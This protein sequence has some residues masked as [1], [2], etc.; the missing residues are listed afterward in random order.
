MLFLPMHI[1]LWQH[2]QPDIKDNGVKY[3]K[4]TNIE[5]LSHHSITIYVSYRKLNFFLLNFSLYHPSIPRSAAVF[6]SWEIVPLDIYI[7][8]HS[9]SIMNYNGNSGECSISVQ[10]QISVGKSYRTCNYCRLAD[11]LISHFGALKTHKMPTPTASNHKANNHQIHS[12][13][14]VKLA[15][16]FIEDSF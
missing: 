12:Q 13:T 3:R 2:S 1:G 15:V 7:D 4:I 9:H 11:C 8:L 6:F 14:Y 10:K 16:V 5:S